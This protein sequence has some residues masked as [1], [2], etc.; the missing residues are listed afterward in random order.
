MLIC[1]HT[2]KNGSK[3]MNALFGQVIELVALLVTACDFREYTAFKT[4]IVFISLKNI[5][6]IRVGSDATMTRLNPAVYSALIECVLIKYIGYFYCVIVF[7][8][9]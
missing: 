4:H 7:M 6:N 1:A 2:A 3:A 8:D 9:P 5:K